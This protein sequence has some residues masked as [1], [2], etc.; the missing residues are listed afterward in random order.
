MAQ[1]AG[2]LA[3]LG[4]VDGHQVASQGQITY[5]LGLSQ[6]VKRFEVFPPRS[7]ADRQNLVVMRELQPTLA[8]AAER[9]GNNLRGSFDFGD[10]GAVVAERAGLLARFGLVDG[11]Q[12]ARR[13]G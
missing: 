5:G 3:R 1:R 8:P 9:E 11:D 12:V 7:A 10:L 4:L 13:G 6:S 2:L